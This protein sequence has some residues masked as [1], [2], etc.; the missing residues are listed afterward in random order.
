[1]QEILYYYHLN[2][3]TSPSSNFEILFQFEMSTPQTTLD[4]QRVDISIFEVM[5]EKEL[6]ISERNRAVS[7]IQG[8]IAAIRKQIREEKIVKQAVDLLEEQYAEVLFENRKLENEVGDID[9]SLKKKKT[10]F[11]EVRQVQKLQDTEISELK[12][13]HNAEYEAVREFIDSHAELKD[14][15]EKSKEERILNEKQVKALQMRRDQL[16]CRLEFLRVAFENQSKTGFLPLPVI[17][18]GIQYITSKEELVPDVFYTL[19]DTMREK[20]HNS[21]EEGDLVREDKEEVEASLENTENI[22]INKEIEQIKRN[23]DRIIS[24]I[25]DRGNKQQRQTQTQAQKLQG[26][27]FAEIE[28]ELINERRVI[29]KAIDDEENKR[30]NKVIG[31]SQLMMMYYDEE[32]QAVADSKSTSKAVTTTTYNYTEQTQTVT[33]TV[34]QTGQSTGTITGISTPQQRRTVSGM[35]NS[36]SSPNVVATL[37]QPVR[38]KKLSDT[39]NTSSTAAGPPKRVVGA[40]KDITIR[41]PEGIMRSASQSKL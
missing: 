2:S 7:E 15:I 34:T 3:F 21:L 23:D 11:E 13:T 37:N 12:R 18:N 29:E 39:T 32:R 27:S 4:G 19:L 36:T 9:L 38:R 25:N 40:K 31:A 1:M 26:K 20:V 22:L 16:N 24:G 41:G 5:R 8:E 6:M 17:P 33:Q 28:R 35:P 30:K 10:S 14:Q